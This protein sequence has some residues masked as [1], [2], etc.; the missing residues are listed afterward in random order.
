MVE[1]I[2]PFGGIFTLPRVGFVSETL[3]LRASR[4]RIRN[5]WFPLGI[6]TFY[7]VFFFAVI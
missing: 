1:L 3:A 2:P 5:G 4:K 7:T 6:S